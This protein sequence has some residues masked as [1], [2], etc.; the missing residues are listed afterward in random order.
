MR[1]RAVAAGNRRKSLKKHGKISV[2]D[3]CKLRARRGFHIEAAAVDYD[4]VNC[5]VSAGRGHA[6]EIVGAPDERCAIGAQK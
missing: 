5:G 2:N 4:V 1:R 3:V 6:G